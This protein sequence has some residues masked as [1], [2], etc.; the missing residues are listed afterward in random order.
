MTITDLGPGYGMHNG[1]TLSR[2]KLSNDSILNEPGMISHTMKPSEEYAGRMD[3]C[4]EHLRKLY[5]CDRLP[6][7]GHLNL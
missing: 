5:S 7:G 4:S 6:F 2:M 1:R 3:Q